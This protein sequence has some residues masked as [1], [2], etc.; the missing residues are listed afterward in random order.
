MFSRR[1]YVF[2]TKIG[3]NLD[4]DRVVVKRK[5]FVYAPMNEPPWKFKPT[6][7]RAEM[8]VQDFQ[9]HAVLLELFSTPD[10][11]QFDVSKLA[12]AGIENAPAPMMDEQFHAG[13]ILN[14][15]HWRH[16]LEPC[17]ASGQESLNRHFMP[18]LLKRALCPR[19]PWVTHANRATTP[20]S[21]AMYRVSQPC[22]LGRDGMD[23]DL[24]RPAP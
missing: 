2:R 17:A 4:A 14:D 23:P 7:C 5:T 6:I 10:H 24:T 19:A 20:K 8:F 21:N 12:A 13:R 1:F 11:A 9:Q 15:M 18:V 16:Q 22:R 3:V